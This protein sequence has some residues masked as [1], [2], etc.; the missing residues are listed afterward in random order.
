M[1]V[2]NRVITGAVAAACLSGL[3][4]A[5]VSA[6]SPTYAHPSYASNEEVVRGR[7]LSFNGA[8]D[9][10]LRDDRGFVD[11]VRLHQGTVI[12]PTGLTLEAGMSVTMY[13]YNRG[14]IFAANEIDTPYQQTYA[15]Y[16]VP[17]YPY[18][19]PYPYPYYGP[20]FGFGFGFHHRWR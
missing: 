17:V 19:Y 9:L 20:A 15:L 6:Q 16:P 7:V 8:Y 18:P 5:P 2:M 1:A 12:N 4:A 14:N 13:G 3:L 10:Q 11:N